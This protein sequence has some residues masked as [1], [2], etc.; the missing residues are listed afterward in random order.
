MTKL[1]VNVNKIALIR[2]S[3]DTDYP[4]VV[5]MAERAIA[6]GAHGITVHP[7]PDQRHIRYSDVHELSELAGSHPDVEF[8]IEGNPIPDLLKIVQ[9]VRPDQCTLVP[10]DPNQLTSDHGWNLEKAGDNLNSIVNELQSAGVR[11][12][13]FMDPVREQIDRVKEVGAERIELYTEP[14][15]RAFGTSGEDAV[16]ERFAQAALYAESLGIGVNAGH[17]LNLQNLPKFLTIQP[18]L[19]VSI[20]HAIVVE[21]FDH[22]FEGA[23]ARYLKI[24]SKPGN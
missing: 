21:S 7:R 16:W 19:E 3:R 22:G 9:E 17:D 13:L 1:S 2:N 4:N 5:N 10:D 15:A 11:A 14:Y 20:G 23:I 24:V 6:A 12:S 8:N 18:I